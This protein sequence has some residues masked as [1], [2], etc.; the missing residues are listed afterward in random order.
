MYYIFWNFLNCVIKKDKY[1]FNIF[2]IGILYLKL[3][4]NFII[5][6]YDKNKFLNKNVFILIKILKIIIVYV[7][8]KGKI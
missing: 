7:F 2:G 1:F 8:K 5:V 6:I 4:K 3:K